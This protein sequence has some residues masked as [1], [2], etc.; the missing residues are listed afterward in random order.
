VHD[1]L[2]CSGAAFDLNAA[3]AGYVYAMV[4]ADAMLSARIGFTRAL[5]VGS[6]TLSLITDMEDRATAV[7]FADGA[8]AIVLEWREQAEPLLLASDLGLDGSLLPILYCDHGGYMKMEG[9]EVFRKA[10]R[11]TVDSAAKVLAEAGLEGGDIALFVPHQANQRIIDAMVQRLGIPPERSAIV[12]DRTGNTSSA[13]IP[14]ALADAAD[15]GRLRDGDLVLFS[16]FGAGMT[17]AS[18]IAR[19]GSSSPR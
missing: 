12:L 3:C 4:V 6:D 7:L 5:V 11:V 15:A 17:W 1:Q 8:G 10:V 16:G 13:S 18:A 19:W 14:L 9:K 2:G